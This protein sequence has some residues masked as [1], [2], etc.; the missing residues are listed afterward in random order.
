V[1]IRAKQRLIDEEH[2]PSPLGGD[3]STD[4]HNPPHTPMQIVGVRARKSP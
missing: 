1:R 4:D 2:A 3:H